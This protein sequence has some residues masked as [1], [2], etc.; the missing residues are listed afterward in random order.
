[1]QGVHK[2]SKGGKND[3]ESIDGDISGFMIDGEHYIPNHGLNSDD[4]IDRGS[5]SDGDD[6]DVEN[7]LRNQHA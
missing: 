3:I 4:E 6:N 5:G 2:G 7:K 1:M